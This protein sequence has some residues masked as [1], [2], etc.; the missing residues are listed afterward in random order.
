MKRIHAFF[1][2]LPWFF[3]IQGRSWAVGFQWFDDFDVTTDN[4]LVRVV[5]N[6]FKII[7]IFSFFCWIATNISYT[8]ATIINM[9]KWF[10]PYHWNCKR[11]WCRFIWWLQSQWLN[12]IYDKLYEEPMVLLNNQF[13]NRNNR[14]RRSTQTQLYSA[15][16]L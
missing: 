14:S 1:P 5:F 12:H 10:P 16:V 11:H 9:I 7:F 15:I 6:I 8:K 2:E 13:L 3:K 4:S